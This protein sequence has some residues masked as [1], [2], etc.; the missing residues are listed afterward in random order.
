MLGATT[1]EA[2]REGAAAQ[3]FSIAGR[4]PTPF[5]RRI[6]RQRPPCQAT[7]VDQ[8]IRVHPQTEVTIV[9]GTWGGGEGGAWSDD[10]FHSASKAL[11]GGARPGRR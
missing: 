7:A 4:M 8:P 5:W 3:R 1:R 10:K 6:M 2:S 11:V 9:K